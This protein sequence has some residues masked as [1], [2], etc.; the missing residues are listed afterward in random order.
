MQVEQIYQLTNTVAKEV[1]GDSAVVKED[2]SNIV[3]IGKSV[4][5][6]NWF[7]NYVRSLINH[8]GKVVFVDRPYRGTGP[9][10]LMD[11]WEYGSVMEKVRTDLLDANESPMW[12]LQDGVSYDPHV[13][14]APTASAKFFNSKAAFQFERSVTE[15]QVKES[16][17]NA[18]QLNGFL[19]MLANAL[20]DSANIR[21]EALKMRVINN[22]IAHILT[23]GTSNQRINLLS[24]YN[25][26]F[27]TSLTAAQALHTP[28]FLRY[29]VFIIG[30]YADR[31]SFISQLYNIG[32]TH[33]HTPA[34]RR[35]IVYLSEFIRAAGVYLY[36]AENQINT[37]HLGLP[38]GDTVPYWQ[39]SG[40]APTFAV[41]SS[42]NVD[43]EG[44]TTPTTVNQTGIVCVMFDRD[45]L[46]VFNNERS[47][48]TEWN[49]KGHFTNYFYDFSA[50]YFNDLDENGIVFYMA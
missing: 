11:G 23:S 14:H 41:T 6:N 27:G 17:S 9:D 47:V 33:K 36:D 40:T 43:I 4:F 42:I 21:I 3:D 44:A 28:A 16:F 19:S 35:K 34:D 48:G 12:N 49:P 5:N 15:A 32:G 1:L 26:E 10:I 2:L 18:A 37:S 50:M 30:L 38:S 8:I 46:G 24:G 45:A 25:T 31:M 13:F 39:G 22:F 20:E 7:D 29:A